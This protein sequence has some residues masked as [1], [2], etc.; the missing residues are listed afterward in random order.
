MAYL[1]LKDVLHRV[2]IK[3][4]ISNVRR[5]D[6]ERPLSYLELSYPSTIFFYPPSQPP[7][8]YK[9]QHFIIKKHGYSI[10]DTVCSYTIRRNI[11]TTRI[12]KS[13]QR[14]LQYLL[15]KNYKRKYDYK[16]TQP[17]NWIY[18]IL[19][20]LVSKMYCCTTEHLTH[21]R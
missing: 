2:P 20:K 17:V 6:C 5:F 10:L 15:K 8:T 9:F 21:S 18:G 3:P 12:N 1:N 7:L 4:K 19:Y 14:K 11:I 13:F 16:K